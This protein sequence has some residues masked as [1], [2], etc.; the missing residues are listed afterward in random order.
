MQPKLLIRDNDKSSTLQ[1]TNNARN[2][3]KHH[4]V[5]VLQMT[6]RKFAHMH[7]HSN[8]ACSVIDLLLDVLLVV[9]QYFVYLI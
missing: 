1:S 2:E 5:F 9:C 6:R 7:G 3:Y 4:V 8:L